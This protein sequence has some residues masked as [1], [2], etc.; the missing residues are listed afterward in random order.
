MV[1]KTPLEALYGSVSMVDEDEEGLVPS[2]WA[3]REDA[4]EVTETVLDKAQSIRTRFEESTLARKIRRSQNY[5]YGMF[6]E[7]DDY[8]DTAITV[9]GEHGQRLTFHL[10]QY[11]YLIRQILTL[12][13]Q[14]KPHYSVVPLNTSSKA[15]VQARVGKTALEHYYE[16]RKIY[17][18]LL[19][20][21]EHLLVD[22]VGFVKVCWN[23]SLGEAI[24]DSESGDEVY[25]GDVDCEVVDFDDLIWEYDQTE[26]IDK[27]N[28]V[29][30]RGRKNRW[31]LMARFPDLAEEIHAA[32]IIDE[33]EA[34]HDAEDR[35]SRDED[36][37]EV[38]EFF[39]KKTD[40]LPEGRYILALDSG[41]T[42]LDQ[43]SPYRRIPIHVAR[44][45]PVP[46]TTLGWTPGFEL[47]KPQELLNSLLEG[48]A[49]VQD[50]LQ[51]P[52]LWS[53]LGAKT[54]SPDEWVGNLAMVQAEKKP[55]MVN[56]VEVPQEIFDMINF[57]LSQMERLSGINSGV[58]GDTAGSVRANRMQIHMSEQS[59]RFNSDFEQ[60][61]NDLFEDVGTAILEI[62]QDFPENERTVQAV[63]EKNRAELV[64]FTNEDIK[65]ISGIA[66]QKA[67]G[68]L[69]TP[70]GKLEILQVLSQLN[71]SVPKEEAISILEGHP[72]EA[73]T[74]GVEGQLEVATAENEA[75]MRG[76]K[77][78][79]ALPTDNHLMHI[80]KHVMILNTPEARLEDQLVQDTLAA[81]MDHM[82]QYNDP[83]L[84]NLQMALG[85][86]EIPPTGAGAP[87]E[88]AG[89]VEGGDPAGPPTEAGPAPSPTEAGGAEPI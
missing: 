78:H 79:I 65:D 85:Y 19:R 50:N 23:P 57:L 42:L 18:K 32:G 16:R 80:K 72:L 40:A 3:A 34:E 64:S 15:R 62:L 31:D 60:A 5:Y 74:E 87:P 53:P 41:V 48:V 11:R 21:M 30:V 38:L 52:T 54:S 10:N 29:A 56:M 69:R 33:L 47:Q 67:N 61:F 7:D 37:V 35:D 77:T 14:E 9:T 2:Y 12:G 63:G 8:G 43:P 71:I 36:F 46:K 88:G 25:E 27:L 76:E 28:W 51:L 1:T 86:A 6:S 89:P 58:S 83:G 68:L 22:S 20:A 13:T 4:Q 39:H 66:V 17:R 75:L 45:Q 81:I 73:I 84:F 70:E 49:T 55:E 59:Q 44:A 82:E 26:D 24:T